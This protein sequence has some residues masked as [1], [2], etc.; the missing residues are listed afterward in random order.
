MMHHE[1]AVDDQ[2]DLLIVN[3]CCRLC[4]IFRGTAGGE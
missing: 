2:I 3:G 4:G 1:I